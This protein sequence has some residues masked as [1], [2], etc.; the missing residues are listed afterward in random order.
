MKLVGMIAWCGTVLL[1]ACTTNPPDPRSD[2]TPTK[3]D[4]LVLADE[5]FRIILESEKFA[6]ESIYENAKVRI[7]YLPEAELLK[8]MMDDSVRVVFTT[9]LPGAEQEAYFRT[10]NL[11]PDVVPVL[12]DGIALVQGLK[13]ADGT[14]TLDQLR[15]SISEGAQPRALFDGAGTGVVRSLV[16]S[17]FAGNASQVRTA[18]TMANTDSLVRRIAID[19]RSV[20]LLSFARISDLDNPACR[21]LREGLTL[22][23]VSD[24]GAAVLPNQSTLADG[25]YPL[26]RTLYALLVEGRSGL[27]TGFVSFVAGHK[28][29]RIILKSGLAPIRVPARNVEIINR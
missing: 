28:G 27:G 5:D 9:C 7:T 24:T 29:Q 15:A 20:G 17:L 26:R 6:F 1:A 10:R 11:S 8:R 19:D 3:G 13:A 4:I 21:A 25:S 2:D 22:C 14:I 23:A 18:S 16:D 12:T